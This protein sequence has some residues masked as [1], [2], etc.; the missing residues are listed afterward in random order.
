MKKILAI[1]LTFLA[2]E[3]MAQ[4]V[5][6][7]RRYSFAKSYFGADISYFHNLQESSFLN[8]QNQLQVLNR[9]NFIT[10]AINIG[11]THFWGH[12]DFFVSIA[13]SSRK[14]GTD[15]LENSIRFRAITGMRIFP[16]AIKE[17]AIRPYLSYKFAP[18]RLN[19]SDIQGENYRKTQVKSILGAGIAYQTPKIYAYLGYEFIPNNETNIHLSRTQT[20]TSSFPKGLLNFGINYSVEFTNGSYSPPIP[21]LDSILR[22]KNTLGLFFGIGPSSAFPTQN[23]SYITDLYSFLD[24]RTMSNTFPE[25]TAG[26][27]FSKHEFVISANFRPMRQERDAFGFNQ[28]L[29][30]NSFGLEAYKFLFDYHGFAPF[31]GAGI[32]YDDIRLTEVDNAINLTNDRF[33]FL[34]P[35]LVFGWDIRPSRRADI[36]LLRTNLRYSPFLEL[37]KNNK[38]ISLQHLEFNFIQAVIYPQR[39]KKYKELR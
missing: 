1:I 28:R 32:M 14:I 16:L 23:S 12:A 30:R 19:Q 37:E 15:E 31:L 24:D 38:K 26:Y 39:I 6:L 2:L 9:N 34:T 8:E 36:W 21:Q 3:G 27:H 11:A 22:S 29:R 13:T 33:T 20:A 4:D 35:S 5:D 25:I 10:P 7:K 18:I 17:N